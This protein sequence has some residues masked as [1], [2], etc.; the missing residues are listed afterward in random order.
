M[1]TLS[2]VGRDFKRK[3]YSVR[4]GKIIRKIYFA[5]YYRKMF[6]GI[7]LFTQFGKLFGKKMAQKFLQEEIYSIS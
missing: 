3:K 2:M 7:Y 6:K 5:I 4:T 1:C